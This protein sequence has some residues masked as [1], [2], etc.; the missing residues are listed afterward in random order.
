MY[1]DIFVNGVII[2]LL[3]AFLLFTRTKR[4]S[5]RE[6]LSDPR[7][8]K[9]VAV[10]LWMLFI[11]G[12]AISTV[13]YPALER[14]HDIDDAVE[15]AS[16]HFLDGGN[17]YED[18][19]VPRFSERYHGEDTVI[20]NSTYNYLPFSLFAYSFF[21]LVLGPLGDVWFPLANLLLGL[22]SVFVISSTFPKLSKT[23]I[24]PVMGM[25]SLF[26]MF[27]NIMLSLL[28]VSIAFRFLV[29]SRSSFRYFFVLL[30]LFL[31]FFV[32]MV[33]MLSLAVLGLY[34]LQRYRFENKQVILQVAAFAGMALLI[35]LPSVMVFGIS[36]VANSTVF[37]FSD[38]SIRS[39]SSG[40]GGTILTML[41]GDSPYFSLFTNGFL[42]LLCLMSLF[43]KNVYRR[44]FFTES[45]LPF[46]TIKASQALLVIP[47]YS[48]M[49][50][51]I[52]ELYPEFDM[53]GELRP[54]RTHSDG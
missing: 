21:Y 36:N 13:F 42:V 38:V 22:I 2:A 33:G 18:E 11:C 49:A 4:S 45:L 14:S 39:E 8:R 41:L 1:F 30:F 3:L 17:P 48:L 53:T 35:T 15:A 34:L 52:L 43:I 6:R 51:M 50:L 19:V 12:I 26:F 20:T 9:T 32:K 40:Y 24:I 28:M 27:D 47:F 54:F 25:I 29:R 10:S 44:I 31:G 46:V 23:Y 5:I 16:V 37:Y 7:V